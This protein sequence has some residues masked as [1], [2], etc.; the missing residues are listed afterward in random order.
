ML[1]SQCD[2]ILVLKLAQIFRT[3]HKEVAKK[4]SA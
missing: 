2:Q 1:M 3:L 4:V